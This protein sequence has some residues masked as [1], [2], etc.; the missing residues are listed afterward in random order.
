MKCIIKWSVCLS[1]IC[2]DSK[3]FNVVSSCHM[4]DVPSL[5]DFIPKPM[6]ISASLVTTASVISAQ[7]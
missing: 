1:F 2:R 7:S 6:K 3:V 5:S 4:A